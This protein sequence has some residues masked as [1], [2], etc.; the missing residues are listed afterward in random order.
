MS[1][2]REIKTPDEITLLNMSAMMVDA[3]YY[4]LYKAMRPGMRENE[5][6]SLVAERLYDLGSEYVEAV[7]AIS[8]NAAARIHTSSPIACSGRATR[9]T[10]TSS[11][12]TWGI[13][14]AITGRSAS[15]RRRARWSMPT[16]GAAII[17]TRRSS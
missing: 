5:A 3:A 14:P 16:S 7:N 11:I 12:R 10:T 2:A 9:C 8:V 6:V 13:A 15:V 1:I 17:S 4:D